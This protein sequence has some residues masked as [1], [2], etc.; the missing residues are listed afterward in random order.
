[1]IR[2]ATTLAALALLAAGCTPAASPSGSPPEPLRVA[3]ASDLQAALPALIDAFKT[4]HKI[5]VAATFGA[6]GQLAQQVRQGAPFDVF[7]AANRKFVTDLADS[8]A[9][10][11]E[12]VRD[13][14]IGSL[15]LVVRSD[16]GVEVKGIADLKDAAIKKVAHANPDTAPYGLA[17]RQALQKVRLW[18]A[19]EAKRVQSETVRQA[20]QFVQTGNAEAG[21]VGRAIADVPGVRVVAIDPSD[22]DPIVQALGIPTTSL[23]RSDAAKFVDFLTGPE[24][25]TILEKAGFT[26]P[27]EGAAPPPKF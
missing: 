12:S 16:L 1:M 22:Y 6:S 7:L 13:Y 3:A 9:I 2:L 25:R 26:L 15:V 23:H 24:G 14:A 5:D 17:A 19:I 21:L 18:D 4:A 20:L 10:H 11:R 27:D 8:G